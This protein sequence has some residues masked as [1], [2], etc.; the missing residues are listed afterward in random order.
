MGTSD[1][2]SG[3]R[4]RL[5]DHGGGKYALQTSYLDECFSLDVVNDGTNT[6]PCLAPTGGFSG[7]NWTLTPRPDGTCRLVN[8]KLR[9]VRHAILGLTWRFAGLAGRCSG[10]FKVSG[11]AA[12]SSLKAWRWA[13]VG[14]V[15]MAVVTWVP[16]N[17]TWLRVKVARCS[18]R[19][20]KLR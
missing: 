6:T 10:Y 11:I 2:S 15:S 4:W 14:S 18:S 8:P 1:D 9:L 7:Q 5:V 3:Q 12:L 19:P 13:L 16:V 20:R 17:R